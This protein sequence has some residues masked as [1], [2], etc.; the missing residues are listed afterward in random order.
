VVELLRRAACGGLVVLSYCTGPGLHKVF[1]AV[2]EYSYKLT[3][4]VVVGKREKLSSDILSRS[5]AN[6]N[7]RVLAFS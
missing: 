2:D 7:S 4:I 6:L 5:H 1:A 3:L